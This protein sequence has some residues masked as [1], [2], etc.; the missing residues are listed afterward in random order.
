MTTDQPAAEGPS[1]TEEPP[2]LLS[3]EIGDWSGLS[4]NVRLELDRSRTV[5]VGKNGAGKSLLI[6][7]LFRAARNVLAPRASSW[8]PTPLYFRCAIARKDALELAYEYRLSADDADEDLDPLTAEMSARVISWTER[9]WPSDDGAEVWRVEDSN[10]IVRQGSTVPLSPGMGLHATRQLT[11]VEVP[12]EADQ[13]K[14]VLAG[15]V[16][17]PAGVPREGSSRQ[18]ILVSSRG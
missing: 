12:A 4:G 7:G 6:E 3:I 15:I 2:R 14:R 16:M 9:C 1:A 10:L 17:V 5:L 13:I 18:E 8:L 11:A